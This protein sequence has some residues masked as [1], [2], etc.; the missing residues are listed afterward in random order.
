MHS[1]LQIVASPL[2]G[3]KQSSYIVPIQFK[4]VPGTATDQSTGE[5]TP[6]TIS[7][8]VAIPFHTKSIKY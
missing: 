6:T 4:L 2:K 7:I 1:K 3:F 8:D 5:G